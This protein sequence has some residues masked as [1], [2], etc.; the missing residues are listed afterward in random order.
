MCFCAPCRRR[1]PSLPPPP[2]PYPPTSSPRFFT[3]ALW[4]STGK[5]WL[6]VAA[7]LVLIGATTSS[8]TARCGG[9]CSAP[10]RSSADPRQG[11]GLS[12][13]RRRCMRMRGRPTSQ[14]SG[15]DTITER[16]RGAY[17]RMLRS[18]FTAKE[19]SEVFVLLFICRTIVSFIFV[20]Y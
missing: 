15:L 2:L 17:Y 4:R 19:R 1:R 6:Q 16:K 20:S 13:R 10:P 7:Q 8:L 3:T 11:G 18:F 9:S 5:T 12:M 14:T